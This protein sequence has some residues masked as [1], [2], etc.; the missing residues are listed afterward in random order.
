MLAWVPDSTRLP[1]P[2]PVTV[3]LLPVVAASV[4]AGTLKV[5]LIVLEAASTSLMLMLIGWMTTTRK[6]AFGVVAIR[7]A[8]AIA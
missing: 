2:E 8:E 1:V 6:P 5:T 7:R 4:P 3:T